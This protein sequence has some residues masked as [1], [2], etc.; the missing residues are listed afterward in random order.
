MFGD[1]AT[2]R[3]R[4]L[5]VHGSDLLRALPREL[6]LDVGLVRGERRSEACALPI[7]EV[8]LAGSQDVP[9]PVQRVVPTASVAVELLL[10]AAADL[11]DHVGGE[12]D[13]VERVQ[14][15]TGVVE[16]V[17]DRV[18]VPVERVQGRDLHSVT[19]VF[20]AV[21]EP[22]GVHLSGPPRDEVEQ[23]GSVVSVGIWCQVDHPGEFLRATVSH[24]RRARQAW[25]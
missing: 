16:T 7:G 20:A 24:G 12:F 2:G 1:L 13:D 3:V 22:V 17:I 10:D 21:G 25:C 15:R 9:D 5:V 8:L 14:H 11:I 23:S 6:D 19:K 4:G 18:L